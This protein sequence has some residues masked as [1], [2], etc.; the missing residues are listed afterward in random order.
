[1]KP[2]IATKK[3]TKLASSI[4]TKYI[5]RTNHTE[6]IIKHMVNKQTI[7]EN[8]EMYS[9]K[10]LAEYIKNGIITIEELRDE[11]G[12]YLQPEIFDHIEE[13]LKGKKSGN[14]VQEKNMPGKQAIIDNVDQYTADELARYIDNGILTFEELCEETEGFLSV[15]IR[16]EIEK[17]LEDW[18]ENEWGEAVA[19]N[20]AENY[21]TFAQKYPESQYAEEARIKAKE[22]A[23][24]A[25]KKEEDNA[26]ENVDKKNEKELQDFIK[27]QPQNSHITEARQLLNK[28]KIEAITRIDKDELRCRIEDIKA[29]SYNMVESIYNT[30]KDYIDNNDMERG[31]LL[32]LIA[33]DHNILNSS[34]VRR[35]LENGYLNVNELEET[36]IKEAFIKQLTKNE[37]PKDFPIPKPLTQINKM[38][39]EVYF[40]GIPSSGKSCALGGI[41]SVANNGKVAKTMK[42]DNECQGYGYMTQLASLF[43]KNDKVGMLPEGTSTY[44]TYEMAFD[45]LDDDGKYHPITCVDLAGE[46]LRCMYKHDAKEYMEPEKNKTLDTLTKILVDKRTKNRKIHFFVLE[47]GA[48]DHKY[49]GLTQ[50]DYLDGALRYIEHTNIF[51][52]DTDSIY[53]II[54]KVDKAKVPAEE[55]Q[56]TLT[57]YVNEEYGGFYNGIKHICKEFEINDGKVGII[58][59]TLGEVC[60]EDYCLFNDK[61]ATNIVRNVLLKTKGFKTGI[62]QN[63]LKMFTE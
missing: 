23:K 54:T 52:N 1:M 24:A 16:K 18:E 57:D 41:L 59:F 36:G 20:S 60:F 4:S 2:Q 37:M 9:A 40:W 53:L 17:K 6:I 45:L 21:A 22:L 43:K 38:S 39:T 30:L 33:D 12:N 27:K 11:A 48:D 13:E 32:Q 50:R 26:W 34:I 29:N 62:I 42:K 51:K 63:I 46:M 7:I 58:P 8:V 5:D 49:E 44:A 15:R 3:K 31:V 61:A 10:E 56:K 19:N 55:L 47:Y 28:L 14:T 25:L 35:L